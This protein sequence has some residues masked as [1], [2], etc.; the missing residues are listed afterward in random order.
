MNKKELRHQKICNLLVATEHLSVPQLCAE[1]N[2]SEA[3]VR[4]DLRELESNGM[5]K[6]VYGGVISTGNTPHKVSLPNRGNAHQTE[7]EAIARYVV[8]HVLQPNQTIILDAGTT[9]LEL[10]ALLAEIDY[11]LT[12]AT[13]SLPCAAILSQNP[14]LKLYIAGGFYDHEVGSCHDIQTINSLNLLHMDIYFLCLTGI[15]AETGFTVPDL[16]GADVKRAMMQH[17]SHVIALAD[18][19]KFNKTGLHIVCGIHDLD[20]VITDSGL[21]EDVEA[22]FSGTGL[23]IEKA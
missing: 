9:T 7:K 23:R 1:L 10:A 17:A 5:V 4:N 19:S 13:N 11:P 20:C 8:D 12:I 15:S 6:R 3:T 14:N 2:C 18:H 21:P 16:G 22:Q